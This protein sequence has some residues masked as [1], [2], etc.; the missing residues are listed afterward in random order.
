M[1]HIY[2]EIALYP[3]KQAARRTLSEIIK[4]FIKSLYDSYL[5]RYCFS[6]GCKAYPVAISVSHL[7]YVAFQAFVQMIQ[8]LPPERG[9]SFWGDFHFK[10]TVRRSL[11]EGP[12]LE[13]QI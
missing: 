12:S 13:F 1:S 11:P 7:P 8:L 3:Q 9:K 2:Q 10:M 6:E 5:N 4:G